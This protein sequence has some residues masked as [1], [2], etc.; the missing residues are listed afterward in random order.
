MQVLI[1]SHR[2]RVLGRPL[3]IAKI[4]A[5]SESVVIQFSPDTPVEPERVIAL[6]QKHKNFKLAGPDRLRVE[7][8]LPG[9]RER[10]N[11]VKNILF[12]LSTPA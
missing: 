9:V 8:Q 1:D 3:A 5:G 11:Q 6:V 4:D 12:L 2:L 7:A 10:V